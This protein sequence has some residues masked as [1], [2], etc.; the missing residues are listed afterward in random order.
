[1]DID[2]ELV[3][4]VDS[5]LSME[6]HMGDVTKLSPELKQY[7][8]EGPFK[9]VDSPGTEEI[10]LTRNFGNEKITV[11]FSID[12]L[13]ALIDENEENDEAL[14]DDEENSPDA[15]EGTTDGGKSGQSRS[16]RSSG[17]KSRT[18][19]E[20]SGLEESEEQEQE[21]GQDEELAPT[22]RANLQVAIE[23][24]GQGSLRIA[25]AAQDGVIAIE[26]VFYFTPEGEK[27]ALKPAQLQGDATKEPYAGPQFNNLDEDLQV[28][29]ES[30][31]EER[32]IDTRLAMFVPEYTEWK[33]QQEYVR[34]LNNLKKFVEA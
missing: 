14:F 32:G 3:A 33:E 21:Q 26:N 17:S 16:S 10:V 31:L 4:K 24:K 22:Y 19:E 8:E 20:E 9:I 5:E 2:Q 25:A 29:F 15:I 28:L 7:L 1:M 23:K 27:Q 11:T 13:N 6:K 18:P 34:W 30:Y 12:D